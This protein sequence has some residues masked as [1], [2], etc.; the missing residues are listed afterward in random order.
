MYYHAEFGHSA[1]KGV[2][3]NTAEPPNWAALELCSLGRR[4]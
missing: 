2:G 4:S 3:I 1:L